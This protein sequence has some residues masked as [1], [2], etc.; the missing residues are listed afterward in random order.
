ME[1]NSDDISVYIARYPGMLLEMHL[2]YIGQKTERILQLFTDCKRIDADLISNT[3][4]EYADNRLVNE[5]VFPS[6]DLYMNEMEYFLDCIE[7]KRSNVNTMEDAYH[8]LK[9]ALTEE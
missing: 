2:D 1:I 3:I 9:I 6:E 4:C 8:V 5:M 7:K